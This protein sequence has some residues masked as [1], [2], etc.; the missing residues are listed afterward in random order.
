MLPMHSARASDTIENAGT[1]I[2]LLLPAV[3]YGSTFA[4]HD[5]EGRKQFYKGFF[6]NLG[7]TWALKNIVTKTRPNESGDDSFPS[8]HTSVSFQSAAF[9]QKRY[10]W[11]YGIPAYLLSTFVAWS[12][13]ESDN[14]YTEDVLAGAAIGIASSYIFTHPYK[15]FTVTP[16]AFDGGYGVGISKQW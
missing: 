8:G 6:T 9:I 14:H 15:G 2:Y 11:K 3:T 7:V 13:V 16:V 1:A 12:R 4:I 10:G 5:K